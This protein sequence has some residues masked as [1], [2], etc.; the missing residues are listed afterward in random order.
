MFPVRAELSKMFVDL[1][2]ES[3]DKLVSVSQDP[4]SQAAMLHSKFRSM[5]QDPTNLA[6]ASNVQMQHF[7]TN[8]E[9]ETEETEDYM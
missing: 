2:N 4:A 6:R 9:Q 5:L 8:L 7:L 3:K 1:W